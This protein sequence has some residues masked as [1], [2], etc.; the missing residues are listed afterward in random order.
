MEDSLSDS[1]PDLEETD[2]VNTVVYYWQGATPTSTAVSTDTE[3]AG[4]MHNLTMGL[5]ETPTSKENHVP[6][7]GSDEDDNQLGDMFQTL[8]FWA[9]LPVKPRLD[10]WL[11]LPR[12]SSDLGFGLCPHLWA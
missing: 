9:P 11:S 1:L 3:T 2:S 5:P 4:D 12:Q 10:P 8:V 6:T 7:D